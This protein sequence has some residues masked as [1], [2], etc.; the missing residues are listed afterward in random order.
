MK[1]K[2]MII[3]A[4]H[5]REQQFQNDLSSKKASKKIVFR[6]FSVHSGRVYPR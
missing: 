1:L 3:T 5:V 2:L 6:R 4:D